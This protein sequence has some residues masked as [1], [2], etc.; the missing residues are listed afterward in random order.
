MVNAAYVIKLKANN[1][2]DV[3]ILVIDYEEDSKGFFIGESDLFQIIT[4]NFGK[5]F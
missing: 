1:H 2:L 4:Y 5:A 3:H